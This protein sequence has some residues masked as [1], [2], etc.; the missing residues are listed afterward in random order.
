MTLTG[1]T[2]PS[3]TT[4]YAVPFVNP[5]GG[6]I[7]KMGIQVTTGVAA[8]H[9]ELGIY[10]AVA[11]GPGSLLLDGGQ[12]STAGAGMKTN[13]SLNFVLEPNTLY[14]LAVGCEGNVAVEG[15][16]FG[17]GLSGVLFGLPDFITAPS[18]NVITTAWVYAANGLPAAFGAPTYQ[19]S[20]AVP[21]V[22]NVYVGAGP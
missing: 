5:S 1:A 3:A 15:T 8:T 22:P 2:S 11:G 4:L 17:S 13:G 12:V 21:G 9:C 16:S 7:T 20:G 6:A 14:F 19:I 18:S 10:S